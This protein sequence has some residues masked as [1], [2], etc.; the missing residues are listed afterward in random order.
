V[1]AASGTKQG[2]IAPITYIHTS[3]WSLEPGLVGTAAMKWNC[4]IFDEIVQLFLMKLKI[5]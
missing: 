5:F 2:E 3:P 4:G 1:G